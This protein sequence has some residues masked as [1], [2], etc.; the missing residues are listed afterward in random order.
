MAEQLKATAQK[1]L[2]DLGRILAISLLGLAGEILV[3]FFVTF[4]YPLIC[5]R[6]MGCCR[7]PAVRAGYADTQVCG[8]DN[9]RMKGRRFQI[10]TIG[11]GTRIILAAVILTAASIII[12]LPVS[13]SKKK[14]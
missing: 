14:D 3:L 1:V 7:H 12:F 13:N 8:H 5:K 2:R 6:P 9:S 10:D 11:A 4:Y